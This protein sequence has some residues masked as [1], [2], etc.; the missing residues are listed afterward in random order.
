MGLC[1]VS[2]FSSVRM[3]ATETILEEGYQQI[4]LQ[5]ASEFQVVGSLCLTGKKEIK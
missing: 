3:L 4:M 2:S 1:K 5:I